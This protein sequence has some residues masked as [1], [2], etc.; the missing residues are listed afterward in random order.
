MYIFLFAGKELKEL[1]D[2][3]AVN[4]LQQ[5][6]EEAQRKNLE[7]ETQLTHRSPSK[8][9]KYL[10]CLFVRFFFLGGGWGDVEAKVKNTVHYKTLSLHMFCTGSGSFIFIC[11]LCNKKSISKALRMI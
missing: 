9:P 3:R 6:L 5:K 4:Q 7:L 1:K 11:C 8:K 10:C 2:G